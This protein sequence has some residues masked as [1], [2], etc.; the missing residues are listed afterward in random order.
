M[1]ATEPL[2]NHWTEHDLDKWKSVRGL[3]GKEKMDL[4]DVNDF[5]H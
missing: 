5:Q 3:V 2:S 1:D 4:A